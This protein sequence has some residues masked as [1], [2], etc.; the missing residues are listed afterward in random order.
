MPKFRV[1]V[2]GSNFLVDLDGRPR[3][4]GFLTWQDVTAIDPAAAEEAAVNAIRGDE[5]LRNL[6]QNVADDPPV[7]D[8][9]EIRELADDAE[10]LR[11]RIWYEMNPRRWWQFWRWAR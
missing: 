2:N 9:I 5:G 8:V 6:V 1:Q 7:M 11:G 10:K 4:L 3:K